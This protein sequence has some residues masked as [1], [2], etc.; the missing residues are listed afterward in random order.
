[1][2][3]P[4]DVESILAECRGS[5]AEAVDRLLPLVYDELRRIAHR[6][7]RAERTDHTLSTTALV[8]EVY[9][10]LVDQTHVQWAD[11]AHFFAIASRAM[12]RILVDYARKRGTAKRGAGVQPVALEDA[13]S[14]TEERAGTLLAVDEALTRL[15]ELDERLGRVVECRFFG[16]LTE[17]ETAAALRVTARTVRRD[18]VKAKGWLYQELHDVA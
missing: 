17:E 18:W 15:A 11:R 2:D 13:V 7:L 1:M 14:M 12:R 3:A 9:V 8:H 16:G 10:K 5:D 6:Q 4:R